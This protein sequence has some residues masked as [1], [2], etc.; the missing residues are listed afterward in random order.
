MFRALWLKKKKKKGKKKKRERA[1][2]KK[3]EKEKEKKV[4]FFFFFLFLPFFF[5]F[6]FSFVC[7]FVP[8]SFFIFLFPGQ[9]R[10]W[11][12]EEKKKKEKKSFFFFFFFSFFLPLF[13]WPRCRLA[14]IL[15]EEKKR[16]RTGGYKKIFSPVLSPPLSALTPPS[17]QKK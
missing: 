1:K 13:R 10:I 14:W 7:G 17:L 9:E 12:K 5:F 6:F 4:T 8:T 3:G 2:G 16:K 15:K 11:E